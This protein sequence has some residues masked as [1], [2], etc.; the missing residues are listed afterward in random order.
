MLHFSDYLGKFRMQPGK[1][2]REQGRTSNST[3]GP[4]TVCGGATG[5]FFDLLSLRP[6]HLLIRH[7][8]CSED[9]SV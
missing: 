1:E 6:V 5:A 9:I 3:S 4:N 2:S 7:D 8:S